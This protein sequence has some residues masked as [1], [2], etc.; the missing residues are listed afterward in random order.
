MLFHITYQIDQDHRNA[1]QD[2]FT[3]TGAPPPDGVTMIGRWHSVA[4]LRGF[5]IAESDSAEALFTWTQG[6]TDNL[7]FEVT[8]VVVDEKAARVMDA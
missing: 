4:A 3:S 2:R 6:W 8:P 5:I 1:A 7:G